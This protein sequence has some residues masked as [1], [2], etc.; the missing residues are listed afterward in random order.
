MIKC[1]KRQQK[2]LKKVAR[3]YIARKKATATKTVNL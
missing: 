2:K 1:M 3:E